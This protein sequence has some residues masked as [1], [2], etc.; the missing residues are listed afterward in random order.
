[1]NERN[2]V[3]GSLKTV[4]L[5]IVFMVARYFMSKLEIKDLLLYAIFV[6]LYVIWLS[7]TEK[8]IWFSVPCL[9]GAIAVVLLFG[10]EIMLST[11]PLFLFL[12]LP[13]LQKDDNNQKNLK[14]KKRIQLLY[15]A[16]VEPVLLLTFL[17]V[18]I[19]MTSAFKMFRQ[20]TDKLALTG[21]FVFFTIVFIYVLRV[22]NYSGQKHDKNN[23][24]NKNNE[25]ATPYGFLLVTYIESV[26]LL[27]ITQQSYGYVII[28]SDLWVGL[29]AFIYFRE[30]KLGKQK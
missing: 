30:K 18:E 24:K 23:K 12:G 22:K 14:N 27:M 6:L 25:I 20:N 10:F 28:L 16:L 1:M 29:I 5:F 13:A 21:C 17:L 2:H 15:A 3:L 4:F 11:I 26:L 8:R 7:L 19:K 9:L